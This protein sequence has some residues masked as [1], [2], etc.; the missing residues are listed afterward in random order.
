MATPSKHYNL[1][2][3]PEDNGRSF[4]LRVHKYVIRSLVAFLAVFLLG[5]GLL[6]Y[7]TGEI[8]AKLQLVYTLR[9]E[10]KRLSE[11]NRQL[12]IVSGKVERLEKLAVYLE[13]LAHPEPI[14]DKGSARKDS[15]VRERLPAAAKVNAAVQPLPT[16]DGAAKLPEQ[17]LVSIPNIQPVEGWITK[18]FRA[19]E[20]ESGHS[21]VDFAAAMGTPIKATAPGV[22]ENISNDRYFGLIISI[23]HEHGF[24]T[25]YGHCSQILV[26]IRDRVHRGQTIGL[27]GNT[28]R[29]SA[30][31]LHYEVLKDGRTV[32]PRKY[33]LLRK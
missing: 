4:T 14:S 18:E 25:R 3:I 7:K 28:G 2:F 11:E 19:E 15:L 5:L 9:M 31:H 8:A 12:R 23:R 10:N 22:V 20:G 21:G 26:N 6:L 29:S 27:V 24:L 32:D 13:R 1:M 17:Y 33:M 16:E 30:P